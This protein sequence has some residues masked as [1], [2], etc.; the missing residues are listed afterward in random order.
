VEHTIAQFNEVVKERTLAMSRSRRKF[1]AIES[2]DA[3]VYIGTSSTIKRLR[4][5]KGTQTGYERQMRFV[6]KWVLEKFP[7]SIDSGKLKLPLP[8]DAITSFFG[9]LIEN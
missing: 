2:S 3:D 8:K 9:R 5:A 1:S 4:T 7:D 6:E